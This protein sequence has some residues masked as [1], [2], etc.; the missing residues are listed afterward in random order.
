MYNARVEDL[1]LHDSDTDQHTKGM[2]TVEMSLRS[3]GN[4]IHV[5][6]SNLTEA[7]RRTVI[8]LDAF[9]QK[10]LE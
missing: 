9:E 3:H 8:I 5:I 2:V 10:D 4:C 1:T 7:F 6:G